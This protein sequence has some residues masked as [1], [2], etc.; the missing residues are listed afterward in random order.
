MYLFALIEGGDNWSMHFTR[1]GDDASVASVT[2]EGLGIYPG[3]MQRVPGQKTTTSWLHP[4]YSTL[5]TISS[6][7]SFSSSLENTSL[8]WHLLRVL[9]LS[10]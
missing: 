1:G 2:V 4:T 9:W 10:L 6:F 3:I 5:P 8:L 7:I